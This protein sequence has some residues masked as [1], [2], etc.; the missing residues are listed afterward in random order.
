MYKDSISFAGAGRVASALCREL[1]RTGIRIDLV[2]SETES[3]GRALADSCD[4][5][6]SSGLHFPDSSK[7]IIVAVPDHKLKDVVSRIHCGKETLVAHTAGSF[8]LDIFPATITRR[9][10]F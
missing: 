4:A 5:E 1:F 2:V 6:W 3:G 9:G 10:V 8:G 7:I